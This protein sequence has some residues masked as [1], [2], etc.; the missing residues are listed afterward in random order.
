MKCSLSL[1]QNPHCV[2][3]SESVLAGLYLL[4]NVISKVV[5]RHSYFGLWGYF[6]FSNTRYAGLDDLKL[7]AIQYY[8]ELHFY[9]FQHWWYYIVKQ[10]FSLFDLHKRHFSTLVH[11]HLAFIYYC[12]LIFFGSVHI[13][14]VKFRE[15]HEKKELK[16]HCLAHEIV[17]ATM[18]PPC[19]SQTRQ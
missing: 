11:L 15:N 5:D 16:L 18:Q 6:D 7:S 8:L 2:N 3:G 10:P 19:T 12:C 4:A 13:R 1:F 9:L 17:D 14:S